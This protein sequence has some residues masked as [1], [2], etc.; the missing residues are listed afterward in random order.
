MNVHCMRCKIYAML[1]CVCVSC[2][3]CSNDDRQVPNLTAES[4]FDHPLPQPEF[5][6]TVGHFTPDCIVIDQKPFW[7][8]SYNPDTL[9]EYLLA[10]MQFTL[11][12]RE[13]SF[14]DLEWNY[15]PMAY[16]I[17]DEATQT[18]GFYGGPITVCV[19]A[20]K[21]INGLHYATLRIIDRFGNEYLYAWAFRDDSPQTAA[22][23]PH[24]PTISTETEEQK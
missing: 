4:L 10:N 21:P 11:D 17:Y 20:A 12:E 16:P 18:H 1:F 14:S 19:N 8:P 6:M 2:F 7:D 9:R 23:I 22:T 5:I 13:L 3:A 24:L 15:A